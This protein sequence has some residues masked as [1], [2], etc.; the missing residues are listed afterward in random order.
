[1]R[2]ETRK[3][4]IGDKE[5]TFVDC[6]PENKYDYFILGKAIMKIKNYTLKMGGHRGSTFLQEIE[7]VTIPMNDFYKILSE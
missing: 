3:E 7:R 5:E 6:F 2:I 1:M 4:K